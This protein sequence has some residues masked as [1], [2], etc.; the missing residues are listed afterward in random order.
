MSSARA[1]LGAALVV[2]VAGCAR[3]HARIEPTPEYKT[4]L[5][6]WQAQR[7]ERL[8]APD[9]WLSL[10]GLFWLKPG[11]NAFGSDPKNPVTLPQRS[12]PPVA[13]S[14]LLEGERVRVKAAPGVEL[15]VGA[16]RVVER[17]LHD[18]AGKDPPDVVELGRLELQ[19]INRSGSRG[20]RVRD[21]QSELR[22]KFL[23]LE[24]FPIDMSYRV[25]ARFVRYTPPHELTL[26]T[27]AGPEQH[28]KVP[29]VAEF[30]LF[31]KA[32]RLEPVLETDDATELFFMM[33]D[34]TSGHETYGAGRY[35]YTELAKNGEVELDFNKAYNPPCALTH[36]ATCPI[37]PK[38]NRLEIRIEAGEKVP[39]GR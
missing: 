37:A 2:V 31:G 27:A 1:V 21:P 16:E 4:E 23:G 36:F 5:E 6:K 28:F 17:E 39:P 32:L 29:G 19:I 12:A 10:V 7:I 14:F 22:T 34:E 24:Y 33:R 15:R 18:D 8:R 35:L 26:S 30:S 3:K 25:R 13:G 9:G 38:Q 20:V 11:E